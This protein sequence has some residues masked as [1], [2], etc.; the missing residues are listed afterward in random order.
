LHLPGKD[1]LLNILRRNGFELSPLDLPF[2]ESADNPD[3]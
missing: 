1:G 2:S 3:Q